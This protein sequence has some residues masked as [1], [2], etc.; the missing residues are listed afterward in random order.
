[1]NVTTLRSR[2]VGPV[3]TASLLAALVAMALVPPAKAQAEAF[4]FGREL[5]LDVAPL[6]GSK[7]VPILDIGDGGSAEIELW[8]N[9]VKAQLIVAGDT[10]TIITGEASTRQCAPDRA[11]ADEDLLAALN[12]ITNWRMEPSALVLTGGSR[13]LRFRAQTN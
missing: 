12:E 7:K 2:F 8:C 3:L 13:I 5:L 9:A 6:R 1:M 4:P 10:V 11:R